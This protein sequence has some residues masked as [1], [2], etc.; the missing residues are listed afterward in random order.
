ML[1]YI[2]NS[3]IF[4]VLVTLLTAC[5]RL[6]DK[7]EQEYYQKAIPIGQDYFRKYYDA[8]V[9]FTEFYI[10]V[11]ISSTMVLKGHLKQD[12]YTKVS[13]YYYFPSLEIKSESGPED[14]IKKRKSEAEVN[15]L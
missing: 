6:S 8:E 1:T 10:N 9:E 12:P 4:I 3:L 11:P 14:F 7:E 5:G 2:R 13:L 15:S